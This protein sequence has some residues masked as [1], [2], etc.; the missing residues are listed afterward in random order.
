MPR[1]QPDTVVLS[2]PF[3]DPPAGCNPG[4]PPPPPRMLVGPMQ[5][6]SHP[7]NNPVPMVLIDSSPHSAPPPFTSL[8]S[9]SARVYPSDQPMIFTS[10]NP[11]APPIC[12]CGKCHRE[13]HDNDQA[14]QCYRGCKFW[15]H[16]TCVG[17]V[18]EAWHMI[19]NEP[20]AE[21]VC[22][23]C[24]VAKQIPFVIFTNS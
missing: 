24:L 4:P 10:S 21:W 23:A 9:L 8:S 18:E 16:R 12:P 3:D 7:I 1:G 15:F 20:Y 11:H 2:N 19:V 6:A 5:P 13:I 22:D 14:I 17:L